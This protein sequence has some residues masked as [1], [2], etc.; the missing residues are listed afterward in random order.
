MR[1]STGPAAIQPAEPSVT[2][3]PE[4]DQFSLDRL[5]EQLQDS[6]EQSKEMTRRSQELLDRQRTG[7]DDGAGA[8]EGSV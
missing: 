5:H 6:I 7:Q 4:Y 3:P 8:D 1:H 2:R